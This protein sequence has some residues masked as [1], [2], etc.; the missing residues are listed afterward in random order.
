MHAQVSVG[1][2]PFFFALFKLARR[3]DDERRTA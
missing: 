1:K 2:E 3:A